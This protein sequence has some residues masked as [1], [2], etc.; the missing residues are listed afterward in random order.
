MCFLCMLKCQVWEKFF[1]NCFLSLE[2]EANQDSGLMYDKASVAHISQQQQ[3]YKHDKK[4]V[5]GISSHDYD[6][7]RNEFMGVKVQEKMDMHVELSDHVSA[8]FDWILCTN[9]TEADGEEYYCLNRHSYYS[10]WLSELVMEYSY[11]VKKSK[12][13]SDLQLESFGGSTKSGKYEQLQGQQQPEYPLT[14]EQLFQEGWIP[15]F[16]VESNSCYWLQ[17]STGRCENYLPIGDDYDNVINLGLEL[18]E[19]DNQWVRPNQVNFLISFLFI[20]WT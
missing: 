6:A 17:L 3:S 19:E 11:A 14:A 5:N 8:W 4:N 9:Q 7:Y 15:F 2:A 20:C 1:E 12:Q 13:K 16:D 10:K 18:Y